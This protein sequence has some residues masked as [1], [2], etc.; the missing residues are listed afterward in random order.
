LI[1]VAPLAGALYLLDPTLRPEFQA[2]PLRA[3]GGAPGRL[4]WFVDG[5]P[6][7]LAARDEA[8]RWPL[9]RGSHDIEVRDE[10]GVTATSRIVVR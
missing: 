8:F 3:R 4:E 1:V 6:V 5:E 7:G 2:L 9:A 10:A